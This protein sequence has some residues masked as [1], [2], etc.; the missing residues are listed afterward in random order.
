MLTPPSPLSLEAVDALFTDQRF[1]HPLFSDQEA[2]YFFPHFG[3]FFLHL[4]HRKSGLSFVI[5]DLHAGS[6]P[7]A[8][9]G[10]GVAHAAGGDPECHDHCADQTA[11][12]HRLDPAFVLFAAILQFRD[13]VMVPPGVQL[14]NDLPPPGKFSRGG[15]GVVRGSC[16]T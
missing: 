11:D 7:P 16:P 13:L 5:C 14:S 1:T 10:R 6:P 4:N 2:F 15:G 9:D 3:I 12:C 8:P